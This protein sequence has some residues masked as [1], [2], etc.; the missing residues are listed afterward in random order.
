MELLKGVAAALISVLMFLIGLFAVY[1]ALAM[2]NKA[3]AGEPFIGFGIDTEHN[4]H[5]SSL[6]YS[7][8]VSR[9]L[10]GTM[11]VMAGV[12]SNDLRYYVFYRNEKCLLNGDLKESHGSGFVQTRKESVGFSVEWKT[13]F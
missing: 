9:N 7:G 6:C 11:K 1:G 12:E 13:N 10:T 2:F 4:K 8:G 3:E 5:R